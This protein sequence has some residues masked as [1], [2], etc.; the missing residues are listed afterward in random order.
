MVNRHV[1]ARFVGAC[2]G[3]N[4]CARRER[5]NPKTK[6]QKE[7]EGGDKGAAKL[8]PDHRVEARAASQSA[9]KRAP[10]SSWPLMAAG[11]MYELLPADAD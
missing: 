9:T 11:S 1:P 7:A 6:K 3:K 10:G 2:N 5:A 8:K 4:N